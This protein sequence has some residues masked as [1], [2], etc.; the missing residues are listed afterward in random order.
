[1]TLTTLILTD[2]IWAPVPFTITDV[3]PL[4]PKRR[5]AWVGFDRALLAGGLLFAGLGMP[6]AARGQE[7][8]TDQEAPADQEAATDSARHQLYQVGISASSV[9]KLLEEGAP[10][11]QYQVYGRYWTTPRRMNRIALRYRQVVGE[12]AEVDAGLRGGIAWVFR[13]EGRWRFYG[14]GDVIAG[15][16]RFANGRESYRGGVSP[17]FGAL[18]FIGPHVSLSLEPRLVATYARSQRGDPSRS[19]SDVFSIEIDE[20]ALLIL[21]VHF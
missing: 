13:R 8:P 12:E 18:F 19:S 4:R 7:A 6:S 2:P 11:H 3:H 16:R 20:T 21:S 17:L 5:R 9:F 15:Y 10:T 14:G 1:M